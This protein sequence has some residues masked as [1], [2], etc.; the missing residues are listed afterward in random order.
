VTLSAGL[1]HDA[2]D[3]FQDETTARVSGA[4]DIFET[5]TTL[6]GVWGEGFKAPTPFQLSFVCADCGAFAAP[7]VDPAPNTDLKPET[8]ESWEVG[9]DQTVLPGRLDVSLT[10]FNQEI[11]NLIDFDFGGRGYENIAATE[12]QGVEV[13]LS[14]R[15]I[16]WARL[17]ATYTFLDAEDESTG[18]Q[19]D[20]RPRHQA[21]GTL[22]LTP[23]AGLRLSSTLTFQ[24]TRGDGD[25]TLD[26]FYLLSLRG[27]YA[28]R[29][30]IEV[31][32][33]VENALDQEYQTAAGFGQPD[34]TGF[35]GVRVQF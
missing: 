18:E 29:E 4:I 14:A 22:S 1:R 9:V 30:D 20:R 28:V 13:A 11:D 27:S 33:R 35:A 15:P 7:G 24:D 6:R 10:Y 21:S 3:A 16:R 26:A 31:F 23:R 8:S 19:L 17:S 34:A 5:G 25:A 12:Q 2:S 32:A